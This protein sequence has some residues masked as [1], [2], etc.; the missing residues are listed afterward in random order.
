MSKP[1]NI[2][3]ALLEWYCKHRR[4]FYWREK[5]LT[6]FQMLL[7]EMLLQKTKAPVVDRFLPDFL[8]KYGTPK[9]IQCTN[10]IDLEKELRYLGLHKLRALRMKNI[11]DIVLTKYG[12]DLPR[13]KESLMNFPGVG[14]YIADAVLCFA[15]E[16]PNS[17]IDTNIK[18]IIGRIFFGQKNDV[19]ERNIR[20]WANELHTATERLFGPRFHKKLNWALLDH[21]ALICTTQNPKCSS[22]PLNR[23]CESFSKERTFRD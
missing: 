3:T 4:I 10:Q 9:A 2:V 21:G 6:P 20:K 17:V 22:C 16:E 15:F 23:D 1:E 12:G 13:D 14:S 5:D 19:K 18:R 8:N 7:V 11:A